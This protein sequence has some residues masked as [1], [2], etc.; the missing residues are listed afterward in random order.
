MKQDVRSS[1]PE[2]QVAVMVSRVWRMKNAS[3]EEDEEEETVLFFNFGRNW[4]KCPF[5]YFFYGLILL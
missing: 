1:S 4:F 2:T 3:V 5:V